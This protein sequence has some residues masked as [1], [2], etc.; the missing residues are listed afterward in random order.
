M[1]DDDV[2]HV[3]QKLARC[4]TEKKG[5]RHRRR[6]AITAVMILLLLCFLNITNTNTILYSEYPELVRGP[7]PHRISELR[8][9][10]PKLKDMVG[11]KGV[12]GYVT[13]LDPERDNSDFQMQRGYVQYAVV[14]IRVKFG[15][16]SKFVIGY[17]SKGSVPDQLNDSKLKLV[18]RIDEHTAIYKR[19][20][21]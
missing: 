7:F 1:K 17:F 9:M 19:E 4:D 3:R 14:P 16:H 2:S 11:A 21:F 12:L 15:D 8:E 5:Q 10:V 20:D 13:D 18:H 6:T